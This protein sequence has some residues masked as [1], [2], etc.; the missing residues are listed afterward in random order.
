M[1]SMAAKGPLYNTPRRPLRDSLASQ[2]VGGL[3]RCKSGDDASATTA[4]DLPPRRPPSVIPARADG[5][6]GPAP[7]ARA[8][9]A[10]TPAQAAVISPGR[11]GPA[12]VQSHGTWTGCEASVTSYGSPCPTVT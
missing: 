1:A 5:G 2:T 12:A 6:G 3:E 8:A 9:S 4:T 10:P 7:P 11:T